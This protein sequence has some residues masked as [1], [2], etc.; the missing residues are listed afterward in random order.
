MVVID[1]RTAKLLALEQKVENLEA[2]VAMLK[3][4]L[5][6]TSEHLLTQG[7]LSLHATKQI[8]QLIEILQD[9]KQRGKL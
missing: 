2:E 4:M 5:E 7:E 1:G 8:G 6:D 9:A 3:I